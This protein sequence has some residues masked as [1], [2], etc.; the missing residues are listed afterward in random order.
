MPVSSPGGLRAATRPGPHRGDSAVPGFACSRKKAPAT[1]AGGGEEID[2]FLTQGSILANLYRL[3]RSLVR[4]TDPGLLRQILTTGHGDLCHGRGGAS[5][6][7]PLWDAY[8]T[9]GRAQLRDLGN[10]TADEPEFVPRWAR[11]DLILGNTLIDI[12]TGWDV[13]DRLDYCLNQLLG[14]LLLNPA[15]QYAIDRIGVHL[16]RYATTVTWP[17]TMVLPEFTGQPDCGPA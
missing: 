11:E 6:L 15:N 4:D 16:A 5:Y 10:L 9:A 2:Q 7:R 14:Y 1:T 3:Y 13:R 8:L 12:K 17:V